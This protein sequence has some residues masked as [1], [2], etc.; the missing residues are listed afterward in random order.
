MH[1][2]AA[3]VKFTRSLPINISISTAAQTAAAHKRPAQGSGGTCLGPQLSKF[4]LC[5]AWPARRRPCVLPILFALCIALHCML[6]VVGRIIT[7]RPSSVG[8]ACLEARGRLDQGDQHQSA[9]CLLL[10]CCHIPTCFTCS[11][12]CFSLN[13][14]PYHIMLYISFFCSSIWVAHLAA[15]L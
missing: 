10:C 5:C 9:D 7:P 6:L 1:R 2:S 14:P 15:T 11:I 13:S 3:A 8:V 12:T 4:W